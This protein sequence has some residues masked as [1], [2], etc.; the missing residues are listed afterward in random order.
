MSLLS[1][2]PTRF[3]INLENRDYSGLTYNLDYSYSGESYDPGLGF[4][5]RSNFTQ[6]GS[7]VG[8]GWIPNQHAFINR[9][10]VRMSGVAV[11]HNATGR[12]ESVEIGPSYSLFT[13]EAQSLELSAKVSYED[14]PESFELGDGVTV[15]AGTYEFLG[16]TFSYETSGSKLYGVTVSGYTG[17]FFDGFRHTVGLSPRWNVNSSLSLS[18]LFE[19]NYV[20]FPDR[21]ERLTATV[22]RLRMLYMVNTKFSVSAFTQYNSLANGIVSNLRVR[23]NPREGNDLYIVFNEATHTDR[24]RMVPMLPLMNN[25]TVLLKY[26]YTFTN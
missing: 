4:Q 10:Q 2:D 5:N 9:H 26:T 14:I 25:R 1:A 6:I 20:T 23:Y 17:S 13:L 12:M 22:A 16:S 11:S 15:P 19:V 8:L 18:G 3:R 21:D 7:S 24:D